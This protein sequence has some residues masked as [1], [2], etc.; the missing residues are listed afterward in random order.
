[1][2]SHLWPLEYGHLSNT[3]TLF[4]PFVVRI[5]QSIRETLDPGFFYSRACWRS[6]IETR[7]ELFVPDLP[8]S[9]TKTIQDGGKMA[10]EKRVQVKYEN[11]FSLFMHVLLTATCLTTGIYAQLHKMA[12]FQ[13]TES[14]ILQLSRR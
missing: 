14:V 5:R 8:L 7:P 1:M 9:A 13:I 12:S 3:D 6:G 4:S 2:A 11:S 10:V